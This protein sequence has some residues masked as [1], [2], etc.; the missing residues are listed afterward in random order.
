M[1]DKSKKLEKQNRLREWRRQNSEEAKKTI[2]QE[3]KSFKWKG[4]IT[5]FSPF[6]N[7]QVLM[8]I[9]KVNDN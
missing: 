8:I 1:I 6:T 3:K 4:L 7:Y 2:V 5:I 9:N